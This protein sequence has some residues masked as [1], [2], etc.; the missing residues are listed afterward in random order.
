MLSYTYHP[1][2][3]TYTMSSASMKVMIYRLQTSKEQLAIEDAKENLRRL[4]AAR[5]RA[6]L[7]PW[8]ATTIEEAGWT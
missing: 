2:T 1:E 3:D 5:E 7:P 8:N 4:H 6:G